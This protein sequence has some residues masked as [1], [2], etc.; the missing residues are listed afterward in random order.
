MTTSAT[1]RSAGATVAALV[2][3][4]APAAIAADASPRIDMITEIAG[5]DETDAATEEELK[6]AGTEMI[7]A[8]PEPSPPPTSMPAAAGDG[9][10]GDAPATQTTTPRAPDDGPTATP[11]RQAAP[12]SM[13]STSEDE[14]SATTSARGLYL[15]AEAGYSFAQDPDGSTAAGSLSNVDAG[16]AG[17][18]RGGL[19]YRWT[20]AF[21][22]ELGGG[23]RTDRSL[24]ATDSAGRATETDVDAMT[25]MLSAYLDVTT[26]TEYLGGW[27]PYLGAGAGWA[28]LR[29]DR[30]SVGGGQPSESGAETDN[31]TY[32]VMLG[33]GG[34]LTDSLTLDLGYRFQNLGEA[35]NS[36]SLSNGSSQSATTWDDLLLHELTLGL[37]YMF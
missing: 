24:S 30:R 32:A 35:K 2:L 13:P 25:A 15:R 33:V 7:P 26:V 9:M 11:E 31:V 5:A 3:T 14:M 16:G 8:N 27:T 18:F 6:R 4:L 10:T 23:Y 37:R 22:L 29:T 34:P 17:A 28:R 12:E 21:R 20:P 1:G 36:G 19:G